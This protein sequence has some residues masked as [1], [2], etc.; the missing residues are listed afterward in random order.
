LLSPFHVFRPIVSRNGHH[1]HRL[2]ACSLANLLRQLIAI[3]S[4]HPEIKHDEIG[5]EF[6]YAG[7]G[8]GA[9]GGTPNIMTSGGK[10]FAKKNRDGLVVINDK[11]SRGGPGAFHALKVNHSALVPPAGLIDGTKGL[12]ATDN[13]LP[14]T[15]T[16]ATVTVSLVS[17]RTRIQFGGDS[18]R[19]LFRFWVNLNSYPVAKLR[20]VQQFRHRYY[21]LT[22][23]SHTIND[24]L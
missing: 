12:N 1:G 4:R 23:G 18:S 11:D 6:L 22:E 15:Q 13:R 10:K 17:F 8:V 14:Y 21:F 20:P 19:Q 24:F 7:E 5:L 9:A 3:H 16:S 2:E